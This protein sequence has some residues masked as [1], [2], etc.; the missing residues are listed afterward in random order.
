MNTLH[1]AA[2]GAVSL[3]VLACW[4]A[5]VAA[6]AAPAI[7]TVKVLIDWDN[8]LESYVTPDIET[9]L[10]VPG[11]SAELNVI[12]LADRIPSC[13]SGRGDWTTTKLF[14]VRTEEA[15]ASIV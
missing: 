11:S 8:N 13:D 15:T 1:R 5:T 3:G 2:V 9:E 14:Y 7:W 6:A 12:A 10:T 4:A